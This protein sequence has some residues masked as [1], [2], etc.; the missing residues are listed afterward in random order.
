MA[1]SSLSSVVVTILISSEMRF[2]SLSMKSLSVAPFEFSE[3][4]V[5]TPGILAAVVTCSIILLASSSPKTADAIL[6]VNVIF[7]ERSSSLN[8]SASVTCVVASDSMTSSILVSSSN[9]RSIL[10]L[11][12]LS[13]F[14]SS[15][16]QMLSQVALTD[17]VSS[18]SRRALALLLESL[19]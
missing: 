7:S 17:S 15:C 12:S 6:F 16:V 3:S 10:P 4:N 19:R 2:E 13:R 1:R 8:E 5:H 14:F 11:M 9:T 18:F